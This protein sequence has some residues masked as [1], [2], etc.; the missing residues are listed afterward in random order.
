MKTLRTTTDKSASRECY[1][2]TLVELLVSLMIFVI[3]VAAMVSMEIF[4]MRTY[5]QSATKMIANADGRKTMNLIRDQVRCASTVYVGIY[6]N[7]AFASI[8]SGQPQVGNAL[9]IKNSTTG[10]T[11][12]VYQDP[13]NTNVCLLNNGAVSVLAKSM[14]NYYCFHAEDFQTT[15]LT[16]YQNNPVIVVQMQFVQWEYPI[17]YR[18]GS[19]ANAYNYYYLRSRVTMRSKS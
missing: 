6:S 10:N 16:N 11:L 4:D 13:A 7:S 5:T 12:V 1:A 3:I 18:A 9:Q 19:Q 2:F 8:P 17:G 15:T 14:T